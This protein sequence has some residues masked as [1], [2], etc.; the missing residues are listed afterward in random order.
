MMNPKQKKGAKVAEKRNRKEFEKVHK[1]E[2]DE[3]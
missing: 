1:D 2:L 3:D